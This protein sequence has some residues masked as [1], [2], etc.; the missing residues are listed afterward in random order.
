LDFK[1][2]LS[3]TLDVLTDVE[4]KAVK[5]LFIEEDNIENDKMLIEEIDKVFSYLIK[6]FKL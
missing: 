2:L 6:E 4:A 5:E 3:S 1:T